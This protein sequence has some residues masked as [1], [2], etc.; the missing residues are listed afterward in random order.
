MTVL[1]VSCSYN[2]YFVGFYVQD[3][4]GS[5]NLN[6]AASL[7]AE[8]LGYAFSGFLLSRYQS[9]K[10]M[11]FFSFLISAVAGIAIMVL[12]LKDVSV[13]PFFMILVLLAKFGLTSAFN[14]IYVVN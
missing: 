3:F 9:F 12:D 13:G 1:W 6:Q 10:A 14:A 4:P 7:I 5:L 11:L 2:Y 8:M